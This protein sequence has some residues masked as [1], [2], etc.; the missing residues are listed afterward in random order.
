[1]L[2]QDRLVQRSQGTGSLSGF[3]YSMQE[4]RGS[5]ALCLMSPLL[6]FLLSEGCAVHTGAREREQQRG[7]RLIFFMPLWAQFILPSRDVSMFLFVR[8]CISREQTADYCIRATGHCRTSIRWP[9]TSDGR[10]GSSREASAAASVTDL[11]HGIML[12]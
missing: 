9:S 3:Q 2:C 10:G 12:A 11:L 7:S 4:R 8:W 1:M 6:I 5:C